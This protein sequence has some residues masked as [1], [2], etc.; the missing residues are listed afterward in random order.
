LF[1]VA[2]ALHSEMYRTRPAPTQLTSFYLMMSIGGVVG[3]FFCAI[4][5]PLLFDWTWEHPILILLAALLLPQISLLDFARNTQRDTRKLGVIMLV[6]G[7]LALALGFFGG[8]TDPVEMTVLKIIIIIT[9]A[10]LAAIVAGHRWAFAA[11]IAGILV[12][13][14][15]W[16]NVQQTIDG[17]RMRSYFG[18]YTVN[19][20]ESGNIRWLMHGTTMHGM[21][22]LD[23]PTRPIS[24]Y[25]ATS[26]P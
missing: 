19:A 14:G 21:Q 26:G 2:V 9:V 25:P 18:T 23:D 8:V 11:A 16:Y 1:F 13:N 4:V 24:Y 20:S 3:G 17:K 7:L 15:G 5:A 10:I 6:V 22:L 12:V